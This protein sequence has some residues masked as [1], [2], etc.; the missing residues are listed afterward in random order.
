M[1]LWKFIKRI[2]NFLIPILAPV[3]WVFIYCRKLIKEVVPLAKNENKQILLIAQN[4]IAADHIKHVWNIFKNDQNLKF[5]VSDDKLINRHFSKKEL[6]CIVQIE[7]INI[8]YAFLCYWDLIIYVNHPWG[9][10][11][12]FA[13]F[14][15]KL[16][17]NHGICTGKIN[18]TMGEDGVYGKS[19]VLRPYSEPFYDKMFAASFFEKKYAIASCKKLKDRIAVT[20][21]LRADS[22]EELER[23]NREDIRK[24]LG[25]S[26][27]DIVVHIIS[28]WGPDSLF[29]TI[30]EELLDEAITLLD[31]Y[32]F[33]FSL[34][35]R[36]DEFG[37]VKGRKRKDILNKY[38][39][40]GIIPASKISWD[41]Y[42]V[43]CDIA[44]SDHSSLSLYY[45]L[46][47]KPIILIPVNDK[48]FIKDSIFDQLRKLTY[49]LKSA[50]ELNHLLKIS[51]MNYKKRELAKFAQNMR[52]YPGMAALR[53]KEEIS[54]FLNI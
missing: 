8:L 30:G 5:Y 23:E 43:A 36:H 17:I 2:G 19:R 42:V 52:S 14:I 32:K 53:Y 38:K 28:T 31:K 37:D 34:H 12:W 15:K 40:Q 22:V 9:L 33:V 45:I 4:K 46:L 7:Q 3:S 39:E 16:Y 26:K 41:E 44:I 24:N 51:I 49:I 1:N 10:G 27:D 21:F 29:Q 6:T 48:S 35:P 47:N 25:Y 20:G 54:R 11:V 13:P 50:K 18:N